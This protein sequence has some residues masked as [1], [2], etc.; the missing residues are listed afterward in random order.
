MDDICDSLPTVAKAQQMARELDE[1]F[2]SGGFQVKGWISNRVLEE[3]R[4]SQDQDS[5]DCPEGMKLLKNETAEK[6]LGI[7]WENSKEAFS[8]KVNA[9]ISTFLSTAKS[10]KPAKKMTKRMILTK[11]L[12][13]SIRLDSPPLF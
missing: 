9:D 11:S 5:E 13:F 10:K 6:I 2:A 4:S 1:V 7:V 8:F 3:A 12:A